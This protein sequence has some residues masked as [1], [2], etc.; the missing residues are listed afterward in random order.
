MDIIRNAQQELE[1][2]LSKEIKQREDIKEGKMKKLIEEILANSLGDFVQFG[3]HEVSS[4]KHTTCLVVTLTFNFFELKPYKLDALL[5]TSAE[6]SL[7]KKYAIL[8]KYQKPTNTTINFN[9][10]KE[11]SCSVTEVPIM[12]SNGIGSM[13]NICVFYQ[14][15]MQHHDVLLYYENLQKLGLA[16]I[17]CDKKGLRLMNEF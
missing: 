17:D 13:T 6:R 14:N 8:V 1:F 2:L 5:D 3:G 16:N 4:I 10:F 9:N 11:K 12:F 15:E 7:C